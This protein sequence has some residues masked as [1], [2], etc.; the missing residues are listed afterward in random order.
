M[1]LYVERE[2]PRYKGRPN[3]LFKETKTKVRKAYGIGPQPVKPTRAYDPDVGSEGLVAQ[4]VSELCR[5]NKGILF[6]HPGPDSIRKYKIRRFVVVTDFVGSGKRARDYLEAAWRVAS[7]K[8]WR[9]AGADKGL[10]FEVIAYAGT[11]E[12]QRNVEEHPCKP[13]VRFVAGCPTVG[14][15]SSEDARY[16]IR[17]IC[18][19]YDPV[20]HDPT[21]SLGFRSGGALIAFAHGVPNNAPRIL[22]K[23]AAK[24]APLFPARVTANSRTHFTQR[25]DAQSIAD[26]LVQM[27]QRGL[28]T[29]AW[30][31]TASPKL[32]AL[33]L[34]LAALGRG[35]RN[36]E[37]VSRQT[38]LTQ[39][40][41][42]RWLEHAIGQGWVNDKRRLTDLGQSELHMLRK[43]V[44]RQKP[45]QP[46]RKKMY[47]PTMLRAPS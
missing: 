28:A 30:L 14:Q 36:V 17:G 19:R 1:G 47:F 8:S 22:H 13:K 35:P 38:G 26:R 23:R 42:E 29:A 25:D 44:V 39:F 46:P 4:L 9:S 12:G 7:V 32:Q 5:Q 11:P 40:E 10:R 6:N 33:V 20:D 3:R 21:D 16:R 2:L 45:L 24:W 27:R 37:A 34:V 15:L 18:V 43:T 31:K 41:V